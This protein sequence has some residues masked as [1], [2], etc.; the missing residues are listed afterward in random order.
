MDYSA[1]IIDEKNVINTR[2]NLNIIKS[3]FFQVKYS[4]MPNVK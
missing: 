4:A 3:L 1:E 2:T